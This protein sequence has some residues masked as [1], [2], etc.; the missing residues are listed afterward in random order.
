MYLVIY[1]EMLADTNSITIISEFSCLKRSIRDALQERVKKEIITNDIKA[2]LG[3]QVE[4]SS[5][6]REIM[7][8]DTLDKVFEIFDDHKLWHYSATARLFDLAFA[9]L[10]SNEDIKGR[11][12]IY[13]ERYRG[14]VQCTR[15]CHWITENPDA[16]TILVDP[17]S[18]KSAIKKHCSWKIVD[19]KKVSGQPIKYLNEVWS[20]MPIELGEVDIILDKIREGCIEVVWYIPSIVAVT[21]LNK[22]KL[23]APTFQEAHISA[24]QLEG[25]V[26]FDC[27][28]SGIAS[29]LVR[30][31]NKCS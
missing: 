31:S 6:R 2:H 16:D 5:M 22:I 24:V 8:A 30:F 9:F 23:A 21:L 28:T 1:A 3:D 15:I 20:R 27:T 18:Y 19:S 17:S 26:I 10:G 12:K 4:K 29:E 11:I 14:H 7:A 13:R 25:A